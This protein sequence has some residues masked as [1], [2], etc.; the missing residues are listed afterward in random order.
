M[1]NLVRASAQG[2]ASHIPPHFMRPIKCFIFLARCTL[3]RTSASVN[4]LA[5]IFFNKIRNVIRAHLRDAHPHGSLS[6]SLCRLSNSLLW[7]CLR[8]RCANH[9]VGWHCPVAI[10]IARAGARSWCAGRAGLSSPCYCCNECIKQ[11]LV[12]CS[13]GLVRLG[14]VVPMERRWWLVD[15]AAHGHMIRAACEQS[16]LH[17]GVQMWKSLVA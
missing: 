11:L 16:S 6:L 10:Q 12:M 17:A 2:R 9:P 8:A 14:T 3:D 5:I 15:S 1:T 13:P 4:K 7:R